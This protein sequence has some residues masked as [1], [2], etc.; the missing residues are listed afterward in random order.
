[1]GIGSTLKKHLNTFNAMIT[2]NGTDSITFTLSTSNKDAVNAMTTPQLDIEAGAVQDAAGNEIAAAADQSI[3]VND[4]IKPAFNSATFATGSGVLTVTFSEALNQTTHDAS[5]IH[6]RN[7]GQS[8]GGVTLSNAMITTNGTDSIT[9]TLSTSNK[10]AVNAM[11]TPQ[12]DIEAGAVQDAAG[13]EI[14]AAADQTITI[15]DTIKPAFNSATFAT[16]SGVLKLTFSEALNQTTHDASNIH[17]RNTGQSSGGVTLSNAM[18]T[19]NGTD[20]ITFTLSTSNKDAVNAM[21][22]PQL[23]IEA[24][25]VQDTAGNEIAAAADQTI[26][27]NDTI[28]PTFSSATFATGSGVLKLTFSEALN[29]T[30]H[31]A[32]NI[33]VRNTGQSSG[34]VT[35]SNSIITTNGTNSITFTLSNTHKG[36]VNAM[37]TPQLDIA[38]GAVQDTAGNLIAAAADQTITINDTIR[39]TFSSATFATG[40]GVLTVTFSEALNQTTHDASNI[41]VRNTGQS[42]GGVTLSNSMITTNGTDSITFT[43]STSNKDAVNAMTTPQLDIE[44][45][46]VQD[47]AGNEIAAAADQT[48]TINDTIR[49]TF[50]SATFATGSGVLTV[51]FSEALNQ[52]THDASNIHVRN[53]GQSSGGVTLSNAMI[54]TNGTD[55]ITFT[56]STS[57]KDAVNAMTTPQLDIEAGAVQDAAGNEIVAAADQSITVNDTI[58]PT[59]SSATFA[60][61]SGVLTVTFSEALN[62]TTHDASNIHVRNTG[63]SSGGV[64]LSNAMI[65]TNGTDSITF[66]LNPTNTATV[67]DMATPQ[68]DIKQGAVRDS[69]GNQIAA[70]ADQ[71]ITVNDTIRP[72]FSSAT[73]ATGSGVLKLT[74]S[75]ALNQTTH[76]ASNIHVRNTGQSS[77][78]VTLSNSIITTNGTN[79]ITFTLSNTHKGTVNAMTT[80][81]LDIEQGAVQ[82]TAGNLIAA[83]ADQTIT[84]NDTI[85]PAFNSATFATGSGVLTVTFSEALNQTTH[86]ASNMHVRN[87]GQSSGGVTLSNSMITTNGTDSIT[88]T[89]SNTHRDAVNAMTTPQLDIDAGAVSDTSG[90]EIAV[91]ADQSITINDTILPTFNSATYATGS[92]VLTVTFSEAL[93]QTTH[94]ASNIHVRNT[95]QSSGGVTLSNSMITTNGTDSITFTLSNTH[96]D[97]VNAMAAPQLDIEAGAVRDTS[98]NAIAVAADQSITVNDTILPA[99][100]SATFATGSGVLTVTFSE[101][102]DSSMHVASK[103]HVR[104][105]GQ[106][107]GGVTLSNS[108][109][110]T[111]GTDSITFTLSNTHRDAVNAMTTPQ[112]DIEAGAVRDVASN[113][114]AAAADQTITINDTIK[115]TISSIAYSTGYGTLTITFSEALNQTTHDASNIHVRNTGQSSGGVTLSNSMITTNGTNSITFT[116]SSTDKAT[117]NTMA[118]PQLDIEAGAVRDTSGNEIAAAADQSITI[119]DT[120]KPTFSSVTYATGSGVLTVTFSENLDSSKHNASKIHVRNTGQS[121]GGVTLSNS[122]I[123][124]NGTN[125]ITFTLS[126]TDKSTVNAMTAPQIDMEAGAV[127]DT[128]G[129]QIDTTTNQTITVNDTI[130]PTFNS[131]TYATGSGVLKVTFS[132]ALNQTTHDASKIHVRNTGQS[133]GGVTLSNSMIT[134]NGTDSITFTL[135]NTHKGTVNAMT[136]PQ[137]DIDAGAVSDTSGNEIAAAADQTITVNDTIKPAFNSATFATGSGV[138]KVTF[139]E[140]LNQTTHDASKIHVRNTGQS[141]GG[142]TLSNSM[143]TTNGTDS[144]TFTLSTSNKNA[145]NAMTTPQLDIEAGAVQ[146]AAGNEIAAAADQSITVNDTI[147]PTFSSATYATGSG[148]LKVTFSEALDSSMHAASNIHVRNTGQSSGGVTLSNSMITT[149]GTDSITFTLSNTHRDA[150]NAM[151]TPQLDIEQGA[152]RD[153]S[154]NQIAASPDQA[155]T[156]N[157]TIRPTF[158]SATFATGSGVLKLTFSEALDSSMH[159]ASKI[160]VR[161]TGQSSGGVTLSNSM[162]TTNGTDSITFTLSN[163]HRD[164]VNAM[165]TPQLDIE[166]GAVRDTSGNQIAASPDQAITINDTIRPTFSSATF[167]T[168]SG[169]LKLT[170]SEAL[171]SSMH[172]ASKIHVRDTGQ[173]SGGVTLSNSMITTNGT[174]SITFTLST[175]NKDAVNAMTTPQL[176]IEQGAVRDSAG[177]Q[178]AAAADQAITVNDTINPTFTSAAFSTGAGTLTVTFSETL[179]SSNHDASKF[180]IRDTGQSS[181]G[182]TL[183]NSMI[184]TNGTNSITFTLSNTHKGTVNAMTTPQLDIEQ[185]AVRDSAGNQIAAA[186]DQA[187][188]VNDTINPTFTSA[189]F[190]TGAGTLT[191][192]FSETLDSSNHDASK[193]HVRDTGQS[194]GGVTLSNSM[195]T[196]N[197]TNSITFTLSNTH[198]GTVNAMTTPQLD[199]EQGAVRD[200]AGNQIAAAAD[201]AITVNDTINPTF[202]SAAFSTGAGTLTVTF[203]ETLD[204]SNHDASKFHI[205]DTGQSSGGVTLSNSMITTNGTNSITFT[206][207]NTHKGTVNA[208]TTPQLD[209]E[210]GA[211]RDSAGNQIAAA[212]DQAITVNDTINP[213]FTSAAFSTGAGTLTVTFSETLDSSN[214]DASKIHVRDTGQSTGGVTLSNSMI[215]T[216][217]T[218]SITFTLSTSK[219][220]VNAVNAMTTPQLDIEQGAV[221]DSAGNQIAAAA[222]QAVTIN[223]TINPTFTSAAFSTGAGTLTVTF[224]ETLDSSNHDASKFHIRDTGQSSGG[225]TLSNSM[226]TTNGTDSITFTLS[227]SNK[228]AVNAMTTPQLDIDA[229]AVSDTSGNEIAAAADQTITVNDTI[230]PAFSSATFA[231]G[232]GVLK[233][234]FSEALNQ[235]THDASNIHVRNTGQSSGGVTLSNSMITTNGTNSVTFTL[236]TSNKDAVNAMATPQLDIDAGA[237]SDTSGNEIAAAADQTITVNDTIKPTFSSATYTTGSGVLNVTFSETLDSSN[238]D[239]S[240]IHV[241][242]TGQ[243]TGGVTLSN[244]MITTNGTDSI[245]FALGNTHKGTVNAMATP[246]LDIDA[247]AVSDS[248][249]NAI[250]AITD[251]SVTIHD[252]T[253]PTLLSASYYTGNGTLVISFSELLNGTVHKDRIHVRAQNS[254]ASGVTP[255]SG[256]AASASGHTVMISFGGAARGN[257][258]ALGGSIKVDVETNAVFD[259]AGNGIMQ[260]NKDAP[261]TVQ[262]TTPPTLSS[263]SY[264]R[265]NGNFTISFSEALDAAAHNASLIHV[266]NATQSAGNATQSAGKVTLS[267]AMIAVNGTYHIQFDLNGS[268]AAAMNAMIAPRADVDA[269]AVRDVAGNPVDAVANNPVN[270]T[271][272]TAK[273][274]SDVAQ[275]AALPIPEQPERA[276]TVAADL[277]GHPLRLTDASYHDVSS[278]LT[279]TFNARVDVSKLDIEDFSIH[280]SMEE[281]VASGASTPLDSPVLLTKRDSHHIHVQLP[282]EQILNHT[283]L[284]VGDAAARDVDGRYIVPATLPIRQGAAPQLPMLESALLLPDMDR[285]HV[286]F[287]QPVDGSSVNA[288]LFRIFDQ[289]STGLSVTLDD[290]YVV[291]AGS[292]SMILLDTAGHV[293]ELN[294]MESP[295]LDVGAGAVLGTGGTHSPAVAGLPVTM[296]GMHDSAALDGPATYNSLTHTLW[297]DVAA[298]DA[299]ARPEL[300]ALSNATDNVPLGASLKIGA[301]PGTVYVELDPSLNVSGDMYLD[302]E[303]GAILHESGWT[304]RTYG[305]PVRVFDAPDFAYRA[306]VDVS[307]GA[308]AGPAGVSPAFGVSAVHSEGGALAAVSLEGR[309]SVLDVAAPVDALTLSSIPFGDI[310]DIDAFSAGGAPH[311]AVLN[312]TGMH[313]LNIEDPASP[314]VVSSVAVDPRY[315]GAISSYTNGQASYVAYADQ[316]SWLV[317]DVSDAADPQRAYR[318]E[319]GYDRATRYDMAWQGDMIVGSFGHDCMHVLDAANPRAP[320]FWQLDAADRSGV[321]AVPGTP[322]IGVTT[323]GDAPGLTVM[324]A[325]PGGPGVASFTPT[326]AAPFDVAAVNLY[327]VP[328]VLVTTAPNAG[329]AKLLA[330]D[331]SNATA[332]VLV[333]AADLAGAVRMDAVKAGGSTLVLL[334]GSG[335]TLHVMS[336][337]GAP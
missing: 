196:T 288:S 13:N 31:D 158:S 297:L 80:P 237:V 204:S 329:G 24:G 157:D 227:T 119:N 113:E 73:F 65:T 178:I 143:I 137:L 23:D 141:T 207:S 50:S 238:H 189:A 77:G 228:D 174:D 252:T 251:R 295:V 186:A 302:M 258:T 270:V 154:G 54:T 231:T 100:S 199:I 187:I 256:D 195:I 128:S 20:S 273:R 55:S 124:A 337:D 156:I 110:T 215:T 151:T 240:K 318:A 212:A 56:L 315:R 277:P 103:F 266:R 159:A 78:G 169:V 142:I 86:D 263:V 332:P 85:K 35:L 101:A 291:P 26:T 323:I 8:S 155:I 232:S 104:N 248:S 112:L 53:T 259:A 269:G 289:G 12:L 223:D 94:D 140:A 16:G 316:D 299:I 165:T 17:V 133:T 109:I 97:A 152:V 32:S 160:H 245:T 5:N 286:S 166:Q 61:G 95:G 84:I 139:S 74:F 46:A 184:T 98:G 15:N 63:Q 247:G 164:A 82:D 3:T 145:V 198:K 335:G 260:D 42:S 294:H 130:L 319:L 88:F 226:I 233:V 312:R 216:N 278:V 304:P 217:G 322:F 275:P 146:D 47:A 317:F 202:T 249:G 221:R 331:V 241:R 14:A 279:L 268:D 314:V 282:G 76:D 285:M 58:L 298:P 307:G 239:A 136:T 250:A 44:A 68:L 6:V 70:A 177:N 200:S 89:L 118:T 197:G 39:P 22:T 225:V 116:L 162:I 293:A 262:D 296:S 69:A 161:D 52:T 2:T 235:T 265:A 51:T 1:M 36:T 105:T 243:S 301:G 328:Y 220:A 87:T 205:R 62:Q 284:V 308:P 122:M 92:G 181:G 45:G 209:I 117:V 327:G 79:S 313:V 99:F 171:D 106:S 303:E 192:T 135:S 127:R 283:Y 4:T 25:A 27:I 234:T 19:T 28:R 185:G 21:T 60:T 123:T 230:L 168:G 71:A 10:D 292:S 211:V 274:L 170:F 41:H 236:S 66:T 183:S 244:S 325:S 272:P 321:A 131:A 147:L 148:V 49:P 150:V 172:A 64:T 34:G 326:G 167:A 72:T 134:T 91:A 333:H 182:V 163:T 132:E 108:M 276:C 37:T 18:I 175:S 290:A 138:L 129:N 33:H 115:P 280:A 261:V 126:S 254:N 30:T 330:Y 193:I 176:D 125:S 257:I 59:F 246:Q 219:D 287:G 81:Q 191:V 114:I 214:H 153:T 306:H 190:S 320:D 203:S 173:S 29:Q 40:S 213:T 311:V 83:A 300:M 75:E 48:I 180:H 255:G 121:S 210:Q 229:G 144:I 90:N 206:L 43:L 305:V 111:N 67:N 208:M 57:N 271:Y 201:Q 107:S 324:D 149:N 253:L 336:L 96:R 281:Y 120:T 7:T 264:H 218:D 224:S 334:A 38:Q 188:T 310:V 179:D 222:D 9:F 93:N 102:L 309:V 267:N 242:N 11:T 194:S